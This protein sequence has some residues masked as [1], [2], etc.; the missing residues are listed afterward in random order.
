MEKLS[1][2]KLPTLFRCLV[3]GLFHTQ[4]FKFSLSH[5]TSI[6]ENH[7]ISHMRTL[8]KCVD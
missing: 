8:F 1:V 4:L 7:I 5:V 3:P 6:K 2:F